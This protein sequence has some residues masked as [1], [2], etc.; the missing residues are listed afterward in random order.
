MRLLCL[1]IEPSPWLNFCYHHKCPVYALCFKK[2]WIK[3][4]CT[5]NNCY[6]SHAYPIYIH[7]Q[8]T[9]GSDLEKIVIRIRKSCTVH[10]A[11]KKNRYID[12]YCTYEQKRKELNCSVT[13]ICFVIGWWPLQ[14]V[15]RLL[16]KV[17]WDRP[18][19]TFDPSEDQEHQINSNS[20]SIEL[21][22]ILKA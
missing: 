13:Y 7:I 2:D 4:K 22:P 5:D 1:T 16:P 10:T 18:Q 3:V 14:G 11:W 9:P 12:T 17:R 8:K 15:S 19:H 20:I 6:S 21:E